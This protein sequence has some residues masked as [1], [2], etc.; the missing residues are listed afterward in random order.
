MDVSWATDATSFLCEHCTCRLVL[1][2]K[3]FRL[4]KEMKRHVLSLFSMT[5]AHRHECE[6]NEQLYHSGYSTMNT[7]NSSN[8][9]HN[10]NSRDFHIFPLDSSSSE[11]SSNAFL[12]GFSGSYSNINASDSLNPEAN[13]QQHPYQIKQQ[14]QAQCQNTSTPKH[15]FA[16]EL[17]STKEGA[18][19]N[20]NITTSSEPFP[21][22]Q[23]SA[24]N[25]ASGLEHIKNET[26]ITI[27]IPKRIEN[28]QIKKR[29]ENQK[30]IKPTEN[31]SDTSQGTMQRWEDY[32]KSIEEEL[33]RRINTRQAYLDNKAHDYDEE[34]KAQDSQYININ[35][36]VKE[37][38]N[39]LKNAE[40]VLKMLLDQAG[41]KP[42]Q[43]CDTKSDSKLNNDYSLVNCSIDKN[44]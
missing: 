26:R 12:Q 23:N 19:A 13:N 5:F 28:K 1:K 6:N 14:Q 16:K 2:L 21:L 29:V 40:A 18:K 33:L 20:P 7:F 31:I 30:K 34:S 11:A 8:N 39:R 37:A 27:S 17:S 9:M 32:K 42:Q 38:H 35:G 43:P 4:R 41:K 24:D 10:T 22:E 25:N 15:G 3:I 44:I 36:K